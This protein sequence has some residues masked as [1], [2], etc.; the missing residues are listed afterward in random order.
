MKGPLAVA[1]GDWT[2]TRAACGG[3]HGRPGGAREHGHGRVARPGAP[4]LPLARPASQPDRLG[5]RTDEPAARRARR[6]RHR[7]GEGAGSDPSGPLPLRPRSRGGV[8]GVVLPARKRARLAGDRRAPSRRG[9]SRRPSGRGSSRRRTGRSGS[10]RR[11][12]RG[13]PLSP[14]RSSGGAASPG[15]VRRR[16]RRTRRVPGGSPGSLIRS[17]ARRCSRGSS[18]SGCPTSRGC[19][20]SLRLPTSRGSMTAGP[21]CGPA[22]PSAYSSIASRSSTRPNTYE[23]STSDTTAA[24]AR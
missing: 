10:R 17:S 11:T 22:P 14:D 13:T 16:W 6:A 19:P 8:S 12:P 20:R 9:S 21:S 23:P 15:G 7:R 4:L 3:R 24:T 18:S 1:W 2:L 5:R